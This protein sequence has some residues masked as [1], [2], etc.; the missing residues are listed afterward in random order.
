MMRL[1]TFVLAPFRDGTVRR[2]LFTAAVAFWLGG[3]TFYGAIVI[4]AGMK[5]LGGHLRQGFITQQVTQ[6][7]NLAGAVALPIMLWNTIAIWPARSWLARLLL[8]TTWV[9]MTLVQTGLFVLHPYLDRLLD[10]HARTILD[11]DRFDELHRIYLMGATVQWGAGMIHVWCALAAPRGRRADA[12]A[13]A[14][15]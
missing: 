3:F 6:S 7:L 10:L 13:A 5:V 12:L 2:F 14:P 9:V 15:G 11:Y 8:A 4:P 1:S